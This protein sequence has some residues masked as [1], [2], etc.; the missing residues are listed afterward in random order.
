[1]HFFSSI[2]ILYYIHLILIRYK[3]YIE[4]LYNEKLVVTDLKKI[5]DNEQDEEYV[6]YPV[7]KEE[8]DKALKDL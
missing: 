7:L 6:E 5:N 4:S 1:M 8:F 2:E 3:E